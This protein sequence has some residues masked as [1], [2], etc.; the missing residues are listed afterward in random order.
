MK[1]FKNIKMTDWTVL[2][3][4][5]IG[6]FVT[7][8]LVSFSPELLRGFFGDVLYNTDKYSYHH[9]WVDDKYDWGFRH[10]LYFYMCLVLFGIQAAKIIKWCIKVSDKRGAFDVKTRD[11]NDD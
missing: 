8:M 10:Y 2:S 5:V 11:D 1:P 4:Q 9:D 7:A 3:L 6:L